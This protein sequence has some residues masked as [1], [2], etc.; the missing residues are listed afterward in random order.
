M[1]LF[2][3][4]LFTTDWSLTGALVSV[5][6]CAVAVVAL[7]K[8]ADTETAEPEGR[9]PGGRRAAVALLLWPTSVFLVAGY[10]ESLFLALAIPAWLAARR[11]RW[12]L[13]AALAA[14]ASCVRITGLFL[15][16][17]LIV[18]FFGSGTPVR[19]AGW[20]ALPFAPLLLRSGWQRLN[21][22]DWL[23]WGQAQEAGWG[24]WFVWP[25]ESLASIWRSALAEERSALLFQMELAGAVFAVGLV[26]LLLFLRR[27]SELVYVGLQAGV[28]ICSASYLA[29]PRAVLLWWPVFVLVARAGARGRWW[30]LV[31]YALLTTPLMLLNALTYLESVRAG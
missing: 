21:G 30:V 5:A 2:A 20:L 16:L 7:A 1:T 8:L 12:P 9:R 26:L 3:A 28:L 14:G 6:A 31:V 17:A 29:I 11:G 13:A 19:R 24:R 10:D 15:A 18:E 27:W 23:T 4:P 22:G 25:W